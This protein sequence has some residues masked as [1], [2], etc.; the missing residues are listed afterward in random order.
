MATISI[1]EAFQYSAGDGFTP[2]ARTRRG[3]PTLAVEGTERLS[4]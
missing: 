2:L 4:V 1:H 3:W